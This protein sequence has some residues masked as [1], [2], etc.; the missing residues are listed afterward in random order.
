MIGAIAGDMIDSPYERY[1]I[2]KVGFFDTG[3]G[4][5]R[6]YCFNRDDGRR[7][8]R[9]WGLRRINQEVCSTPFARRIWRIFPKV[10]V[11]VGKQALQQLQKRSGQAHYKRIPAEIILA[12]REKLTTDLL[13]VVDQFNEKLNCEY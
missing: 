8:P 6:R 5:H 11:V 13:A 9:R 3:G 2:K 1:L 10:D 7:H 12:V 4:I